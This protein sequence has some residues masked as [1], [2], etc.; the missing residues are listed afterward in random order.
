MGGFSIA[1]IFLI[2]T[3]IALIGG[4][5]FFAFS[6]P[7]LISSL[8]TPQPTASI[9]PFVSGGPNITS[10]EDCMTA[11]YPVM[12]SYP[13][14]CALPGGRT[15]VEQISPP[16]SPMISSSMQPGK[17]MTHAINTPKGTLSLS[18]KEGSAILEGE[19]MRSTPCVDWQVTIGGTKDSPSSR[20]E[21]NILD[22]NKGVICIQVLGKAQK[23]TATSSASERTHFEVTLEGKILFSGT[24]SAGK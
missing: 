17:L 18:F 24:L 3:G 13:R 16:P 19:L 14:Q 8:E 10:F 2:I 4:F 15:F 21:F 12:E 1:S 22:K 7:A 23:I 9:L 6:E 11:G 20:V 5:V